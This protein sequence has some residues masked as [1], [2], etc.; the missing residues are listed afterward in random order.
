MM[1]LKISAVFRTI[2]TMDI[3][4]EVCVGSRKEV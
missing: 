4:M 3:Q 1:A 2:Q